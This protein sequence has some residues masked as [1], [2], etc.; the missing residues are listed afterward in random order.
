MDILEY[1]K[2]FKLFLDKVD[3]EQLPEFTSKQVDVFLHE[4][5]LRIIKQAYGKNNIYKQGF[6]E[7][8]KRTDDLNTLVKTGYLKSKV[9]EDGVYEFP[10]NKV[11]SAETDS[12]G[13]NDYM[14]YVRGQVKVKSDT[15]SPTYTGVSLVSQDTLQEAVLDPFNK[16]RISTPIIYFENN[17]IKVDT[18]N[19]SFE[20]L[21]LRIT[22]IKYPNKVSLKDNISSELPEEKQREVIQLAVSIALESVE[23]QRA[24]THAQTLGTIE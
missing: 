19:N 22:Y 8:Q 5:E 6:Q 13:N 10:L 3:S 1:H 24:A 17:A 14:F 11:Y 7:I 4:A 9:S 23:S 20:P 18:D 2:Q 16:S 15:V 12:V 21:Y